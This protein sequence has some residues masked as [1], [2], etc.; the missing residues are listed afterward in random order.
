GQAAS[1]SSPAGA[2]VNEVRIGVR[3]EPADSDAACVHGASLQRAT[4]TL[5]S[6]T[7]TVEDPK[8]PVAKALTGTLVAGGWRKGTETV[9]VTGSDETGIDVSQVVRD[10]VG[11]PALTEDRACDFTLAAPCSGPGTDVT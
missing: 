7:V 4:A 5:Y 2:G 10:G 6:A 8:A 1:W 3:C 11:V 9:S